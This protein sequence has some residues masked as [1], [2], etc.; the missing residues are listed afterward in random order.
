M[1]SDDKKAVENLRKKIEDELNLH[2]DVRHEL[3]RDTKIIDD[4]LYSPRTVIVKKLVDEWES[5][6]T[7]LPIEARHAI[8]RKAAW[9]LFAEVIERMQAE[10]LG[11]P[12]PVDDDDV[13]DDD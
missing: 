7:E 8:L 10:T 12:P 6:W 4:N 5:T 1:T 3:G 13:D 2:N 9:K 11:E